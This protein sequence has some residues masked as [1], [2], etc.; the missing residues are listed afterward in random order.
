MHDIRTKRRGHAILACLAIAVASHGQDAPGDEDG[1]DGTL[2]GVRVEQGISWYDGSD[3]DWAHTTS[4]SLS[5]MPA[6]NEAGLDEIRIGLN[7]LGQDFQFDSL[8]GVEPSAGI[9]LSRGIVSLDVDGWISTDRLDSVYDMGA[10]VDLSAR[11]GGAGANAL[12]VAA[13]GS[14]SD[15]YG[16]DAG[17]ALR[18]SRPMGKASLTASLSAT[19]KWDADISSL[20]RNLPKRMSMSDSRGDQWIFSARSGIKLPMGEFALLAPRLTVSATRSE[21]DVSS[22]S[23]GRKK[24]VSTSTSSMTSAVWALDGSPSLGLTWVHGLF[25]LGAT[26]GSTSSVALSKNSESDWVQPWASASVGIGW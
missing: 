1:E 24:R 8:W 18:W 11:I 14:L 7:L 9:S 3:P 21:I 13:F 17:A 2:L 26:V 19:R 5:W 15:A 12:F 22:S 25:D 4:A 10:A 16:S 6:A 23:G 20:T